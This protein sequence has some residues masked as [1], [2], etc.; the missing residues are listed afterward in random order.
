MPYRQRYW[1]RR[2]HGGGSGNSQ[3]ALSRVRAAGWTSV[4]ETHRLCR[5]NHTWATHSGGTVSSQTMVAWRQGWP[6]WRPS[7]TCLS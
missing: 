4:R 2:C 1:A 5:P 7:A 3:R 6:A